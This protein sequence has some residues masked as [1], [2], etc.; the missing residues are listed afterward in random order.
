VKKL[1]DYFPVGYTPNIQQ[2]DIFNKIDNAFDEGYKF[3]IC[4]AP[5]G[6]G[7]SFIAKALANISENVDP[8]YEDLISSY[9]AYKRKD[10][11]FVYE[12]Q[13]QECNS[14]G[15]FVL[16]VTKNLQDQYKNL[17]NELEILKGKQNYQCVVDDRFNVNIAP[18]IHVEGLKRQCWALNKCPYYN[19]RNDALINKFSALNYSMFLSLPEPTRKRQ[20]LICD[21]ASELEEEFVK[22][23]S[24]EVIFKQMQ[25]L[26][27]DLKPS[28]N[29]YAGW[30]TWLTH[31]ATQLVNKEDELKDK[32]RKQTRKNTPKQLEAI[33]YQFAFVQQKLKDFRML[34]KS[35]ETHEYVIET[36]PEGVMFTPLKVDHLTNPFLFNYA[37]KVVLMSA[38]IIDH[39]NFAKTLGIEKY[40]YIEAKSA[41]NPKNAP[42]YVNTKIKL[43]Y[44]NLKTNLPR[45]VEQI[46]KITNHYK[47]SK[48]IIHTHTQYITDF[49]K[50][51]LKDDRFIFR[52]AGNNNEQIIKQHIETQDPTVIVSPSLSFGVDLKDELARFQIIVKAPFLP[53]TN[54][55]IK[56]LL[57]LDKDWYINKMLISLI[58][59]SGRGIR[60][61]EDHC[62]TFILDGTAVDILIRN[63]HKLPQ[64]FLDRFA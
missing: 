21:E 50:F 45:I 11:E 12:K 51:K 26:G 60:S 10:G 36:K 55:R 7:K 20:Y 6:T 56:K 31:I 1:L 53:L 59:A 37:D 48:G 39:K 40:K 63:K 61:Q 47:D 34:T 32:L 30:L 44:Q 16:T 8:T 22:Y 13:L 33:G 52:E 23:F 15:A 24:C 64:Y 49:L 58:Q 29:T 14:H 28:P 41:F 38:T 25:K 17:F 57:A 4:C 2:T 62:V 54:E 43:N 5:T 27:I 9:E 46:Q 42:I 19:A 35:Y 18:C 3:V